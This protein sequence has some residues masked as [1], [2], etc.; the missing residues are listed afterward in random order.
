MLP[1]RHLVVA[2]MLGAAGAASM[3][4]AQPAEPRADGP[5]ADAVTV[6]N[7]AASNA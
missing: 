2:A 6:L 4:C 5:A 1:A 3:S 7:T